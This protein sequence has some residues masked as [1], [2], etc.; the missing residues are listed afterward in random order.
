MFPSRCCCPG[1]Y[2][3]CLCVL[4]STGCPVCADAPALQPPCKMFQCAHWLTSSSPPGPYALPQLLEEAGVTTPQLH[5]RG[6]LTFVFDDQPVPW[7]VHGRCR[8][9]CHW[10]QNTPATLQLA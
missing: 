3:G 9:L 7:E 6:I 5:H 8:W 1:S 4:H 10:P 2:T